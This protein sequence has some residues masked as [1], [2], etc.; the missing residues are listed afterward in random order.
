MAYDSSYH[1]INYCFS[2][3][4]NTCLVKQKFVDDVLINQNKEMFLWIIG[5]IFVATVIKVVSSYYSEITSNF[6]TETIK[7]EIKIDIFSHLEK[8]PISYFKNKLGDTLSKLTNDTTSLGR[9]G[10][11]IFDMFKEL[12]TVLILTGRMFQV[13][14][15]LALVS[16]ILLPLIIRVV[17]KYT[18]N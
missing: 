2:N 5:G 10:F 11:I 17:R 1:L 14:Y 12:L 15:I 8:L 4:C 7:R 9:I 6:V 16:L 13:D 18:K 3:E